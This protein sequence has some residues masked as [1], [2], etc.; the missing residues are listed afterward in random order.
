M[1]ADET[2]L[3]GRDTEVA[4]IASVLER[5]EGGD[6]GLIGITGE[7]GIGKTRL[8]AQL[9]GEAEAAGH[10]VLAGSA[11]EF[12]RELPFAVFVDALDAYL[13]SIDCSRLSLRGVGDLG[14]LATVFPALSEQAEP[15]P[16]T[17]SERHRAHRAI[18]GLL[19]GL[20]ATRGLVLALDDLHWADAASLELLLALCRRLPQG[21]VLIAV[22]YRPQDAV[23]A[24]DHALAAQEPSGTTTL[25]RPGP[26]GGEQAAELIPAELPDRLRAPLLEAAAGNPFYLEQ[27]AR[28]PAPLTGA[29]PG[30]EEVLEGG[31]TVPAAIAASLAEELGGLDDESMRL[32]DGAAVAG[33]PFRLRLAAEIAEVD[34]DR[35]LDLIDAAIGAG[36]VHAAQTPGYFGFRHPLLRRAV[37][38][39]SGDGW[40]LAAHARAATALARQGADPPSR[41][42]HVAASAAPGDAEAITLLRDAAARTVAQAP[43]SAASWL[44]AALALVPDSDSASRHELLADLSRA[45]MAGGQLE[46][47]QETMDEAISLSAGEVDARLL[48]DL[49]EIDQWQGRVGA[50]IAR[51]ERVGLESETPV[52][53]R[54]QL[55]LRLLYLYRW[56]GDIELALAHGQLALAAA[57][58][59]DDHAVLAGVRA[60]FA[61]VASN[62]DIP[63]A[64]VQY[65]AAVELF[66]RL[67][68]AEL[69]PA[70]DGFYSLGWAAIHLERYEA[71]LAHFERGL[72]IARRAGSVRHL[73]TMRSEP[74]EALI[75]M[76]RAA[77]AIAVADDGVEAA[78][79]H[80]SPRYLWWSLWM[81]SATL[82][83][84]GEQGRGESVFEEAEQVQARMPAQ[85][86]TEIWMGYQRAAML[87][88]AGEHSRALIALYESCGGE[89]LAFVPIPDR[90]SAWEILT[91]AAIAAEDLDRARE[92]VSGAEEIAGGYGL[93]NLEGVAARCRALVCEAEGDQAGAVEAAGRAVAAAQACGAGLDAERARIIVG[94]ALAAEGKRTEAAAVLATAEE[95]LAR[96]GAEGHRAEAAREMR[97]LGRRTR[98]RPAPADAETPSGELAE[99]SARELEVAGLV[100]EQLT[101]R[102]VAERLFLSEKTVESHLRNVFAKL[103]VSSRMAVAQAVERQRITG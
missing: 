82:V 72:A 96:L 33:E 80:P 2:P 83:R 25:L 51:L 95:N 89:E 85:P 38:A 100:A 68:D 60:A 27:L 62:V 29:T 63:S 44:H 21:P 81:L 47:A 18:S 65:E 58:E 40:R 4:A 84:A 87:S 34:H 8:L 103:G 43:V 31:F 92:V 97:R 91:S 39:G 45:L 9:R 53:V 88:A 42:H 86:L 73:T 28:S 64:I 32:L 77:D 61:E 66:E 6:A 49:A 36:L 94:R 37:Y 57:E 20:G 13:A 52:A 30:R 11:A 50:A 24:L 12:E 3:V 55:E 23:A 35:A 5:L 70:L 74:A 93:A 19:S 99:L 56:N 26:L 10:L 101:N 14:E 102:E 46:Q 79:L 48:I 69:L 71:A 90:Q 17:L 1:T 7:P 22:A 59:D 75:R 78:R 76:G 16:A 41:A 98:R 67:S 15:D 54:A